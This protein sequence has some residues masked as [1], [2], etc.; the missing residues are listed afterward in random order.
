MPTTARAP[1]ARPARGSWMPAPCTAAA[2]RTGTSTAAAATRGDAAP[3]ASGASGPGD[4]GTRNMFD[5]FCFSTTT[6]ID[7]SWTDEASN[8]VQKVSASQK[9]TEASEDG[10][11]IGIR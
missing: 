5:G 9:Q 8:Q 7:S 3:R 11:M 10:G 6:F 4:V 2:R 1:S